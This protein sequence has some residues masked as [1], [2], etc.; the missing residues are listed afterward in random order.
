MT[1]RPNA[2]LLD[3]YQLTMA[4]AYFELGM[5]ETAV[6]EM[7]VRRL[8]ATRGFLVAAG[9]EQAMEYLEELRFTPEDLEF[10]DR[11]GGFS[12]GFLDYLAEL[13]FTGSVDAIPEG[14]P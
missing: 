3:L 13:R 1:H 4:H 9:L 7:F 5:N 6:F 2:L 10:L 14:T 8:P 11:L 12:K